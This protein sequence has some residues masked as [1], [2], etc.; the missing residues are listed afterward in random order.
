MSTKYH[1]INFQQGTRIF[2][3]VGLGAYALLTLIDF[4][5][6]P[7]FMA[8]DIV[9]LCVYFVLSAVLVMLLIGNLKEIPMLYWPHL[10]V[11]VS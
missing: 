2:C 3:Y 8:G 11:T 7:T 4:I 10:F 6:V 9:C 5:I 1:P